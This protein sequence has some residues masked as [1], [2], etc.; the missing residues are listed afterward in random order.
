[1]RLRCVP[2]LKEASTSF[3]RKPGDFVSA[4]G[5][6]IFWGVKGVAGQVGHWF[7]CLTG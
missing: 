2:F 5:C 6:L 3:V 7:R 4:V 1:M